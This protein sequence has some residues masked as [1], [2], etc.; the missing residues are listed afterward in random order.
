MYFLFIILLLVLL[1]L[2]FHDNV[3]AV[4][5]ASRVFGNITQFEDVCN[6]SKK[7]KGKIYIHLLYIF[8]NYLY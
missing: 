1:P 7:S 6:F 5:E 8:K 3:E 2:M 4:I